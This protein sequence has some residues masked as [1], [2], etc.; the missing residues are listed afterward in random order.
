MRE[1]FDL[2]LRIQNR[3]G[4]Q[5]LLIGGWALQAHGYSRQTLDVDC[6]TAADNDVLVGEDLAK[7]G[8]ECF[9]EM[10]A[11]RRFR[12]RVDPFLVLDVMRV[13]AGTFAKMWDKSEAFAIGGVTLRVPSLPHLIALKLHAAKNAH[14][15]AKD[16]E[17]VVQLLSVNPGK[18]SPAELR[19]LCGEFGAP[20]QV[21]RLS[22]FL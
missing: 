19:E 4:I 16:M 20:E 11:F 5:L 2:L 13:N 1:I 7:A 3:S 9:D 15:T 6:M 17:D 22:A 10:S 14:R 12:H 18:I 21:H 8:F